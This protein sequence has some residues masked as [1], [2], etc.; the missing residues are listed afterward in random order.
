AVGAVVEPHC[1]ALAAPGSAWP[2][3]PAYSAVRPAATTMTDRVRRSRRLLRRR[4]EAGTRRGRVRAGAR[5]PE[6]TPG[7][8]PGW[9]GPCT[10]TRREGRGC[11][12]HRQDQAGPLGLFDG[13]AA[14]GDRDA[15]SW[16]TGVVDHRPGHRGK[17]RGD[18]TVFVGIASPP[19]GTQQSTQL[20]DRRR[21]PPGA[22]DQGVAMGE[23]SAHLC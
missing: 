21:P 20:A 13:L 6:L 15:R 18:L 7:S 2:C 9:S 22:L 5:L 10:Q 14:I 23:E 17:S 3:R 19:H 16:V 12:A 8:L 11:P 1:R 4:T